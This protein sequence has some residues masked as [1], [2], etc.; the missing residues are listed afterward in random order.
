MTAE[1][2]P[3]GE[4]ITASTKLAPSVEMSAQPD[5]SGRLAT[6]NSETVGELDSLANDS[7]ADCEK[8]DDDVVMGNPEHPDVTVC[9]PQKDNNLPPWLAQ[10]IKYLRGISDETA[11]Q[12]LVTEFITFEKSGPPTGVSLI[13]SWILYL[14]CLKCSQKLPTSLRPGEVHNWMKSKKKD[15]VPSIVPG[16]YGPKLMKWWKGLQPS[17]R[18]QGDEILGRNM[19]TGENWSLLR[20][21]GSAG[22]YTVVMGLS[23][24]IKAQATQHDADSWIIVNDLTWVIQQMYTTVATSS[25]TSTR[26]KRTREAEDTDEGNKRF[27]RRCILFT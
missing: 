7:I 6:D 8:H 11:W 1:P 22:I 21:G 13:M 9:L 3:L 19:P 2:K 14:Q 23:W 26:P 15:S 5:T 17:W 4:D 12:N 16:R 18:A 20:K 25:Y 24:C 27:T 10:P